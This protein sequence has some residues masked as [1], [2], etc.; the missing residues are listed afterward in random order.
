MYAITQCVCNYSVCA[1]L[2]NVDPF[3]FYKVVIL[4]QDTQEGSTTYLIEDYISLQLTGSCM[5]H[6]PNYCRLRG[7]TNEVATCWPSIAQNTHAFHNIY[8]LCS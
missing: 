7:Y 2:R 5:Y 4:Q 1:Q 6:T 3:E 8:N